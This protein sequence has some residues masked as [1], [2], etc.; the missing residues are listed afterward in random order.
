MLCREY[1]LHLCIIFCASFT[2]NV[3]LMV[4]LKNDKDNN[5]RKFKDIKDDSKKE[6]GH[7]YDRFGLQEK[8]FDRVEAVVTEVAK[9]QI[10][11]DEKVM[12]VLHEFRETA[13]KTDGAIVSVL[14]EFRETTI[15]LEEKFARHYGDRQA[16][17][18]TQAQKG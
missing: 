18:E 14:H 11:T 12:G 3:V 2:S 6:F 13:T 9:G 1:N 15:K 7:V 10:R 8:K 4:N 16:E 17:T 5:S